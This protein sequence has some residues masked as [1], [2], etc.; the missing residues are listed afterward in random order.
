MFRVDGTARTDTQNRNLAALLAMVAGFVNSAGF[1]LIGSFTSH[2][3]G[4]VG[5]MVND[6]TLSDP[7]AGVFAALL[8]LTYF[9]GSFVA[10][11]VVESEWM[12]RS[13]LYS[14]LL[15][16]EASL[17][18]LF[19]VTSRVAPHGPR[20]HDVEAALLCLA[21]GM[22]NSF[23]S[24]LSGAVVR[25]THLTGTVTDLGIEAARWFRYWR[26]P[27]VLGPNA[28]EKPSWGKLSVLLALLTG[29]VLGSALGGAAAGGW[30]AVALV[31]P[32]VVLVGA[33]VYS[34]FD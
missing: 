26:G 13:R 28:P 14:V 1:L 9:L 15:T 7:A 23:V 20:A 2:V 17:L 29:F 18:G 24:R 12:P 19:V 5:R 6:F 21:M 11:M 34:M 4:N 31:G 22:Q 16:S 32:I 27:L 33:A 3:T 10:S 30:G 8:V 25:T